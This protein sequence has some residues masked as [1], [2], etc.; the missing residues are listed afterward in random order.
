M[1]KSIIL[2]SLII[3]SFSFFLTACDNPWIISLLP[4]RDKEET[5]TNTDTY[6]I[7]LQ[8]DSVNFTTTHTFDAQTKGYTALERP[9]QIF[10]VV[11]TG[12]QPTG[13]LAIAL[14][15][16]NSSD[17]E[18]VDHNDEDN[19][20]STIDSLTAAGDTASKAFTVR[21]KLNL[22]DSAT[23]YTA[24]VTVS[25]DNV[26]SRSFGVS[27]TV[28]APITFSVTYHGNGSTG[29]TVPIDG[30]AYLAGATVTV[31]GNTGSLVRTS[32]LDSYTFAGWSTV[33][34]GGTEYSAGG[35]FDIYENTNLYARWTL[36]PRHGKTLSFTGELYD[37]GE[38]AVGYPVLTPYSVTVTNTG[39]QAL[40]NYSVVLNDETNFT[41]GG[42]TSGTISTTAP[43][44]AIFTVVPKHGLDAGE[45]EATVTVDADIVTAASFDVKFIVYNTYTVTYHGNEYTG[46]TVP[47][48]STLY[49]E[50]AQVTVLPYGDLERTGYT[51]TG[52]TEQANSGTAHTA[53]S[54]FTITENKTL[55]ARWQLI[56][57]GISLNANAH[58]FP[59]LP[60]GY[61]SGARTPFT[62][63][64]TNTSDL[65]ID[66]LNIRLTGDDSGSFGLSVSSLSNLNPG[67]PG[68]QTFTVQP[69]ENLPVGSY[70]AEVH[71]ADD[72]GINGYVDIDFTV[73][74]EFEITY[75]GNGHSGGTVPPNSGKIREGEPYTVAGNPGSLER[76]V[77]GVGGDDTYTFEGWK[78]NSGG[79]TADYPAG[80]G[81]GT[82]ITSSFTLYA[83][84]RLV[85]RNDMTVSPSIAH[86][87][88]SLRE[89]V[90]VAGD[91]DTLTV[92]VTNAG[93]QPITNLTVKSDSVHA[94][95]FTISTPPSTVP[96]GTIVTPGS[97]SFTVVPNVGLTAGTYTATIEVTADFITKVEF[98]VSF[99]VTPTYTVTYSSNQ[100]T[101]GN[102]PTDSARYDSG[103]TV[104]V[105]GNTGSL[106]RTGGYV[107]AGWAINGTPVGANFSITGDTTLTAQWT[108]ITLSQTSE[109]IFSDEN[110]LV[111]YDP[112]DART[113][114]INNVG[115]RATG[116]LTIA[117][118]GTNAGSFTL[119]KINIAVPGIAWD[120]TDT[121]TVV[122][123]SG[124]SHGTYT[125]TVTVSGTN[126]V[127]RTFNVSFTVG[128]TTGGID[129]SISDMFTGGELE[130]NIPTITLKYT[131]PDQK[132][133]ETITVNNSTGYTIEW[134]Y[135]YG[136]LNQTLLVTNPSLALNLNSGAPYDFIGEHRVTIRAIGTTP[137]S[138]DSKTF[139]FYVEE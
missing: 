95:S 111:G 73:Y 83:H 125:A 6:G 56:P 2:I 29:G 105:L 98:T 131:N 10:T 115:D 117:L 128:R 25:G 41:L 133:T 43:A 129:I 94:A 23:A 9:S 53:G 127:S 32:G 134:W 124:L 46:G 72:D 22:N 19:T 8:K 48:D 102:A 36:N 68:K 21:P 132:L 100:H 66:S 17:F 76:V 119:S 28:N 3:F 101:S 93:N 61:A 82:S 109:L 71:I 97:T 116:A 89:A 18:I 139:T 130:L 114:T 62:I 64:V 5:E 40:T 79:A 27:F 77:L 86:T 137:P 122:P 91:R 16:T 99:T 37:F 52:W 54:H 55:Y 35:T 60:E 31:A 135:D 118:G 92:T 104:T 88:P 112:I 69:N 24:T 34:N 126:V 110:T 38:R 1:K 70:S 106:T 75:N 63:E 74:K 50:G 65:A 7:A 58:E 11:N 44:N 138:L 90:Y 96:V 81:S 78:R 4:D 84:W 80:G 33:A 20:L 59:D 113:I 12:N 51:I 47:T 87:F 107:F 85:E 26:D 13:Q 57:Q 103:A 39:N 120:G 49:K 42:T 67:E 15:G 123:N 108:G 14:S 136:G 121:F 45:Y 30:T